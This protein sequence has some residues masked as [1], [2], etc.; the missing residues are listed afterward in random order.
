MIQIIIVII[1]I[2]AAIFYIVRKSYK[3]INN[4]TKGCEKGGCCDCP[5]KKEC[6]KN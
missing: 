4:S 5:I 6:K 1:I 3:K 2:A